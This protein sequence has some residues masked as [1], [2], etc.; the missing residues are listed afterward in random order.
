[1]KSTLLTLISFVALFLFNGCHKYDGD[2]D[3]TTKTVTKNFISEGAKDGYMEYRGTIFRPLKFDFYSHST[4]KA[5]CIGWS[6]NSNPMRG[7]LSFDISQLTPPTGEKLIIEDVTLSVF[8]V[9]TNLLPFTTDG[10]RVVKCYLVTYGTLA[11]ESFNLSPLADC[12]T[13]ATN[14]YNSL[15]EHSLKVTTPVKQFIADN[16]TN[17]EIQFRLQFEGDTNVT[18]PS[19]LKNA[20]W[21][22]FS[23][24]EES[25]TDYRPRLRIKYHF[26]K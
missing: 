14:G 11:N 16:P 2:E 5:L 18:T 4:G 23:G 15:K 22:I 8:E 13:I 20:M 7:F 19:N 1:M 3:E 12:G 24:D 21:L 9:N 17:K 6:E 25:K 10:Q 26:E